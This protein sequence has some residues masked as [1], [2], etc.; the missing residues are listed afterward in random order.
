MCER[1]QDEAQQDPQPGEDEAQVVADC[2]EDGVRGVA[3]TALEVAAAEVAVGFHVSDHSLHEAG[4]DPGPALVAVEGRNLAVEPFPIDRRSQ[5]R[6]RT[7]NHT[8]LCA[9]C[10]AAR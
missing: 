4:L 7:G 2:G 1:C 3:G 9:S 5:W 10:S 8:G 6:D